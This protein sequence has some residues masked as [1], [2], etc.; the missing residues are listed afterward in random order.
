MVTAG[1]RKSVQWVALQ[2]VTR[3]PTRAGG[4][5]PGE[6]VAARAGGSRGRRRRRVAGTLAQYHVREAKKKHIY[7]I[8]PKGQKYMRQLYR[9]NSRENTLE[10]ELYIYTN[11]SH[12]KNKH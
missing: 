6:H 12:E 2:A 10:E 7:S 11:K 8:G 1:K 3:Q 5:A 4:D 9:G